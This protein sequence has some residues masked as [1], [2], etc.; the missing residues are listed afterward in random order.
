[1]EGDFSNVT[2]TGYNVNTE[3]LSLGAWV[4]TLIVGAIPCVN[5]IVYLVWAFGNGNENRKNYCR[6]ALILM[7]VGLVLSIIFGSALTAMLANMY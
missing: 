4:I 2:Q 1:M 7:A 5:I 6:A 3:V